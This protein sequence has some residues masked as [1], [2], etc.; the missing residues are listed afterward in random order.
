MGQRDIEAAFREAF[1]NFNVTEPIPTNVTPEQSTV[2][3]STTDGKCTLASDA[4]TNKDLCAFA[5]HWLAASIKTRTEQQVQKSFN[6][7]ALGTFALFFPSLFVS[8]AS[9]KLR[10]STAG[11]AFILTALNVP[12]KVARWVRNECNKESFG[13]ASAKLFEKE[14]YTALLAYFTHLQIHQHLPLP[15]STKDQIIR[16]IA[17]ENKAQFACQVGERDIVTIL[18]K[19]GQ[20]FIHSKTTSIKKELYN[21]M[22]S[23][24]E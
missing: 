21:R 9:D 22:P 15:Y 12:E 16:A 7:A 18:K 8:E 3:W 17:D 14:R 1:K 2:L 11:L 4:T 20:D 10:A 13:L 24:N 19:H 6:A 23:L 5:T